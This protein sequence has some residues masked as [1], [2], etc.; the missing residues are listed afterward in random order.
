MPIIHNLQFIIIIIYRYYLSASCWV[1]ILG[2]QSHAAI[3]K[4]SLWS[5]LGVNF[6]RLSSKRFRVGPFFQE[7]LVWGINVYFQD[8]FS[9]DGTH[10]R[11]CIFLHAYRKAHCLTFKLTEC[12]TCGTKYWVVKFPP[13]KSDGWNNVSTIIALINWLCPFAVEFLC[14][15]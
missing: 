15:L 7:K 6:K 8:E 14:Y 11:S 10:R 4:G 12:S 13:E 3:Q 2:C 9:N 5:G 1:Q